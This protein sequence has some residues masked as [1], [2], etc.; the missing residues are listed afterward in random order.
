MI[1]TF[2]QILDIIN[3]MRKNQLVFIA[4]QLGLNYL[5]DVDKTILSAAGIDLTK[6][7]NSKGIIEHA[8][9]FGLLSE[10]L[11]DK[12]SKGMNYTQFKKFLKSGNFIP[13]TE[14]EEFALEQLK[15][16]AYT[17]LNSLGNRIA[18]GTS[19]IIIRANQTYQNKLRDIVK[20]KAMDAVKYRQSAAKLASEIGHATEDWE[21]D[22][23]RI[24]YYLLQDA[25][26]TGRAKSIFKAHGEDAEVWFT[27]L[28][29]A[30]KH[31]RELY[32]K[33]PDDPDSE[34]IVFKLKDIIANGNN[35]GRK[36][37]QLLP[38]ISPIHPYC[39][40]IVNY[41]DPNTEWDSSTKSFTK[42]KKYQPKSKK[43]QGI[44]LNIKVQKAEDDELNKGKTFR[45]RLSDAKRETNRTPSKAE[46]QAG[47]YKKGHISFGGYQYVIENPRGSYRRGEDKDGKKWS[48]RMNNTYGYFL[49]TLG[50]DKDHIDVF[51]NDSVDLDK[52]NG[53]IYVID[54]V[55][56]DGTFD[57]HKVMYG[58]PNKTEAKKAYLSNYEKGWRGC[59]AITG[60][61][62]QVFD[63]W[64]RGSKRK[65]K[66]FKDC[67]KNKER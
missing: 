59:G 26:N 54:Q 50:K 19:N 6:F 35:I 11:G 3:I 46:I 53:K 66:P 21:R 38:T 60:A 9:I 18:T 39:R 17:D 10:A 5:S 23:L 57:E 28:E 51:I 32:L 63:A 15:N 34:P 56:K 12:R 30:C 65:V 13:L 64:I 4:E 16:R 61:S 31:C 33:D 43:L 14:D 40:C 58:F 22:W 44:K 36:A 7:T 24:S 37:D 29:G 47:N 67:V 49:G 27:V 8:F 41:K 55:N 25:Y 20:N 45:Q 62:K 42:V 2:A 48:I 1:F 52:F